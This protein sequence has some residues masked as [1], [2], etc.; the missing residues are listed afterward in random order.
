[1]EN[2]WAENGAET[3]VTNPSGNDQGRS[4]G[5]LFVHAIG[6]SRYQNMPPLST[7]PLDA[8]T[9]ANRLKRLEGKLY[10][11]VVVNLLTDENN[12][13]VTTARIESFLNEKVLKAGPEDTTLIFLAGHGVTD[14]IG[15][16]HFLTAESKVKKLGDGWVPPKSGAFF[17]SNH[18]LFN[19]QHAPAKHFI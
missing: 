16:Y 18:F 3:W 17:G 14:A 2:Q 9:I 4:K 10:E 6:V 7:P 12:S 19:H 13:P 11:K 15:N 1:M 8:R 5:T